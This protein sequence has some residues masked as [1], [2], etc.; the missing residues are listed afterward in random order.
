MTYWLYQLPT[1]QLATLILGS[2]VILSITLTMI[3]HRYFTIA[4]QEKFELISL[5][6]SSSGVLYSVLLAMIAMNAWQNFDDLDENVTSEAYYLGNLYR[7]LEGYP[8]P[9]RTDFRNTLRRYTQQVLDEEWPE[10]HRGHKTTQLRPVV[11][12]LFVLAS[13]FKPADAG[14][15]VVHTEIF[16][17]LNKVSA[18][19]RERVAAVEQSVLPILWFVVWLGAV[20]NLA[21]NAF[22]TTG[23]PKLDYFLISSYAMNIGLVIFLIFSLDHPY[24]GTLSVS[25]E[26]FSDLLNL[27]DYL[28][29]QKPALPGD[30]I[31]RLMTPLRDSLAG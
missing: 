27:M 1:W 3:T 26:P 25:P 22:S 17:T 23:N 9:I 15:T 14:E 13:H 5:F 4:V 2:L 8:E 30:T 16:N 18:L 7:D 29:E 10:L 20:I 6:S 12:R 19:H 21:I 11:D 31:G 24:L 28:D